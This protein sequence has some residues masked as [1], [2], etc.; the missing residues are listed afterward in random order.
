MHQFGGAPTRPV[1]SHVA[2]VDRARD[3]WLQ[4][5]WK[6]CFLILKHEGPI[7]I[8]QKWRWIFFPCFVQNDQ[9]YVPLYRCLWQCP[10]PPSPPPPFLPQLQPDHF[11]SHGYGVGKVWHSEKLIEVKYQL[12]CVF[13]AEHFFSKRRAINFSVLTITWNMRQLGTSSPQTRTD[14]VRETLWDPM[15]W[16]YVTALLHQLLQGSCAPAL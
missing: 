3:W 11:K 7:L 15:M 4:I 1:G 14:T 2:T 8:T 6:R 9:H 5:V 13:I 10:S 16:R 12:Q